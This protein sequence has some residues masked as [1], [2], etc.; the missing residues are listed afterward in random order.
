MRGNLKTP[1]IA[2]G[3]TWDF[4]PGSNFVDTMERAVSESRHIVAVLSPDYLA[5]VYTRAEWALALN[6]ANPNQETLI[7]V[8]VRNCDAN[9]IISSLLYVD[10]VGLEEHEARQ[11]LLQSVGSHRKRPSAPPTFPVSSIRAR[12]GAQ[13]RTEL[14]LPH[15]RNPF[16]VG[17]E[18][19][20]SSIAKNFSLSSGVGTVQVICGMAGVGKT[21]LV[22][23]YLYRYGSKYPAVAWLG[24]VE[25]AGARAPLESTTATPD[26]NR[27]L[28][29]V[30]TRSELLDWR[31][32]LL[33]LDDVD[34]SSIFDVASFGDTR[35]HVLITSRA[36]EW[37]IQYRTLHLSPFS[38]EESI[39]YLLKRT[40]QSD[41]NTA[42]NI[43]NELG[44]LPL[45]LEQA[46]AFIE[47]THSSMRE[48]LDTL[49][50]NPRDLLRTGSPRSDYSSSVA[51]SIGLALDHMA[52]SDVQ[53]SE[54]LNLLAFCD[55]RDIPV[56]LITSSISSKAIPA[57]L[58]KG[59]E[60]ESALRSLA[61][62]SLVSVTSDSIDVHKLIQAITRERL[63]QYGLQSEWLG[64]TVIALSSVFSFQKSDNR[65]WVLAARLVPHILRCVG[66]AERICAP[67]PEPPRLLMRVSALLLE[68]RELTEAERITRWALN[69]ATAVAGPVNAEVARAANQLAQILRAQGNL[70][71][72]LRYARE[73]LTL[74]ERI[75]GP[76]HGYTASAAST[77]AQVLQ[78]QGNFDEAL[79]FIEKA[80]EINL[81]EYGQQNPYAGST[82]IT[83]AQILL[84][85]G[86]FVG[87]LRQAQQALEIDLRHFGDKHPY[88]ANAHLTIGS[89]LHAQRRYAEAL[90]H[91]ES[92]LQINRDVLGDHVYTADVLSKIAA[93]LQDAGAFE[94][95]LSHAKLA[96][97]MAERLYAAEHTQVAIRALQVGEIL[98]SMGAENEALRY[99]Q[100]SLELLNHSQVVSGPDLVPYLSTVANVYSALGR[101]EDARTALAKALANAG[102]DAPLTNQ[103]KSRLALLDG[104]HQ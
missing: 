59:R 65:T 76:I 96:L 91:F 34:N 38:R 95:A 51:L 52:A 5:S 27:G 8:R 103:I 84:G 25:K 69:L 28:S 81:S 43:A 48:Y 77:V 7:G 13:E 22:L 41:S 6:K 63:A 93:V 64:R 61:A 17:R 85:K 9:S 42:S 26:G 4:S 72:A 16:F 33:I 21:Q 70:E 46:A 10:L 66:F 67:S 44:D 100:R 36:S 83:I 56:S 62:A 57:A 40:G 29:T 30:G 31:G 14:R 92:A 60:L 15:A 89:V 53:A 50:I 88:V 58:V 2:F 32:G 73:A 18:A 19:E 94:K 23:E 68:K 90:L 37:P 82:A 20:L 55:S 24:S 99:F 104:G 54:I 71:E 35:T 80:Q 75:W 74:N 1:G 97:E 47:G 79:L 86:D 45:A 49:E 3:Y 87:A 39:Q 12:I 78:A 101:P 11:R 98:R 102:R